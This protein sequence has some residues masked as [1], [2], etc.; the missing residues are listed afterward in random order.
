MKMDAFTNKLADEHDYED[1]SAAEK[2][3][4]SRHSQG[5]NDDDFDRVSLPRQ[6][7]RKSG[8]ADPVQADDIDFELEK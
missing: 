3:F 5:G 4:S 6:D 1:E 2:S 8:A 7:S